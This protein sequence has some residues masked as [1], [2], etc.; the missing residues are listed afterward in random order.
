MIWLSREETGEAI[1]VPEKSRLRGRVSHP[2]AVL[3]VEAFRRTGKRNFEQ[4]MGFFT[5][6]PIPV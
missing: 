5:E 1:S 3:T 2:V 4:E 6:T